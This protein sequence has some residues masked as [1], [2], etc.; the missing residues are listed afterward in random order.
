MKNALFYKN[1][2]RIFVIVADSLGIGGAI[3]S[4]RFGDEGANTLKKLDQ[5]LLKNILI[6]CF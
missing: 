2:K 6:I 5:S 4:K 1:F 3:D